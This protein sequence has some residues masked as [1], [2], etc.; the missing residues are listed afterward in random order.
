MY[1]LEGPAQQWYF[2]L[3]R[4]RGVPT[5]PH[6]VDF[7]NRLFGPPARNNSLGELVDLRRTGSVVDY[8]DQ[9]LVLLARCNNIMGRQQADL[10]IAG[11]RN[12]SAHRRGDAMIGD[13]RGCHGP[14][15]LLRT[16]PTDR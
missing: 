13:P 5:W 16:A 15:P 2:R 12:P 6:F 14:R 4:N 11:L 8:Q 9:F 7:I 10:F 3:E 1:Y